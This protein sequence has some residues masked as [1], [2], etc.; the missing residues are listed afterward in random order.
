MK[1]PKLTE[2]V[3]RHFG[4]SFLRTASTRCTGMDCPMRSAA[5]YKMGDVA[6]LSGRFGEVGDFL[7]APTVARAQFASSIRFVA[8]Q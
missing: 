5:A 2:T 4:L 3:Y 1:T 6:E 8:L 7:V